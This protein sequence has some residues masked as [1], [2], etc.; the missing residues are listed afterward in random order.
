MTAAFARRLKE[1]GSTVVYKEYGTAD[2]D[3]TGTSWPDVK[4][5]L[6]RHL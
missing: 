4:A 5:W 6:S 2:H 3:V 1:A